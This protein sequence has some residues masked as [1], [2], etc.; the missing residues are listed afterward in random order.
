MHLVRPTDT[1]SL[2]SHRPSEQLEHYLRRLK[3][4]RIRKDDRAEI[5]AI[6]A[7]LDAEW[8]AEGYAAPPERA[9]WTVVTYWSFATSHPTRNTST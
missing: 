8:L 3:T 5:D 7:T 6:Y 1:T 4:A 2:R 9:P